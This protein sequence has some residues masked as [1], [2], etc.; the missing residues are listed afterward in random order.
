M[1]Q[2]DALAELLEIEAIKKLSYLYSRACDR[3]DRA[4]LEKVYWPDGGDDHGAFKGSAPDYI[5]WVMKASL[6]DGIAQDDVLTDTAAT[7]LA[8]KLKTPLQI[9]QHLVRAF[10]AAFEIGAKP[11]DA[12]MIDAVLSRH[13]TSRPP[14]RPAN[15]ST[16]PSPRSCSVA[17][18]MVP[19]ASDSAAQ[20]ERSCAR[21]TERLEPSA[22]SR[23]PGAPLCVAARHASRRTPSVPSGSPAS[24]SARSCLSAAE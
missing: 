2:N 3:L 10:E 16:M 11:V 5:D 21:R 14:S 9:G 4:L 1:S 7:L 24:D 15:T 13:A 19:P 8:A 6:Q 23:R 17:Q 22:M 18:L 12:D 20:R